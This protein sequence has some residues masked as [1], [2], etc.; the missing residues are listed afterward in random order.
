MTVFIS[1]PL[2]DRSKFKEILAGAGW[3]V[4][5][6]SLVEFSPLPFRGIPPADWVFFSSQNAVRFFFRNIAE[7]KLTVPA[8]VKWAA[9]G[10]ATAKVLAE[11]VDKVDFTGTGEP[12]TTAAAFRRGNLTILFPSARH[13]RQ[14]VMALLN[15]D[16]QCIHFEI[17]DNRPV[18]DPPH[19][20]DDVLVFTSPMN[21]QAY[22]STHILAKNQRVVAIGQTTAETLR[23]LGI[24]DVRVAAEPTE[25][26]LA[27]AVL[28][29][30][31]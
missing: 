8:N 17:Y 4:A 28:R 29:L 21:A 18:A 19:R 10:E 14:S 31:P 6:Q 23:E 15:P 11:Y 22:F 3:S 13:S 12:K 20:D 26:G 9:L 25:K 30:Q 7:Q 1:R 2:T 24:T 5:G 27:E 16:F